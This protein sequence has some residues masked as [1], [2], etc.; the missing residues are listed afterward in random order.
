MSKSP[1]TT[2]RIGNVSAS[3]FVNE[4]KTDDGTRQLRSVNVQKRYREGDDWK[5]SSSFG[6][7]ELPAAIRALQLAQQHVEE[8]EAKLSG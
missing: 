3:V 8:E 2:F 1:E 6:L 7:A 5:Y 4:V